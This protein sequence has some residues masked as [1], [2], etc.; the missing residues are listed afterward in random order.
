MV[1][2][3]TPADDAAEGSSEQLEQP[4]ALLPDM[5]LDD[6]KTINTFASG[7]VSKLF[8]ARNPFRVVNDEQ[9]DSA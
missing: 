1:K 4:A 6:F 3:L 7:I 2:D 8:D 5:N 9:E